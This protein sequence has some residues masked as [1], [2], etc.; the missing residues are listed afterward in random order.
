VTPATPGRAAAGYSGPVDKTTDKS[1][2]GALEDEWSEDNTMI[3][4]GDD[5]PYLAEIARRSRSGGGDE[6]CFSGSATLDW[7][8]HDRRD[9]SVDCFDPYV[10][11]LTRPIRSDF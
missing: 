7:N 10:V 5:D 6:S 2:A 9:S 8:G 1:Q 11:E 4:R 3:R